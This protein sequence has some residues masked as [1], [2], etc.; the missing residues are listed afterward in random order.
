[1]RLECPQEACNIAASKPNYGILDA[2]VR[3]AQLCQ[4]Q[5][6]DVD[7]CSDDAKFE[8]GRCIKS[9]NLHL[10]KQWLFSLAYNALVEDINRDKYISAEVSLQN[11]CTGNEK[12]QPKATET[13]IHT[14]DCEL[15][16]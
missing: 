11:F 4:I 15:N 6:T 14:L 1:M 13:P 8:I 5:L 2:L 3:H 7:L 9:G 12:V 10:V 16:I